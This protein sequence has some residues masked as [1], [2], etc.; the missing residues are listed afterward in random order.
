M[1]HQQQRLVTSERSQG[2]LCRR[3]LVMLQGIIL[4]VDK[5]ARAILFSKGVLKDNL[6]SSQT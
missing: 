1:E 2:M 5:L 4:G 6:G 3:Q